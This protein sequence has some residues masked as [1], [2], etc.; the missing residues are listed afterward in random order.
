MPFI[1]FIHQEGGVLDVSSTER[2]PRRA[3]RKSQ[4]RRS[5]SEGTERAKEETQ[6]TERLNDA[7]RITSR[8]ERRLRQLPRHNGLGLFGLLFRDRF[9][10]SFPSQESLSD[11]TNA[12]PPDPIFILLALCTLSPL[13]TAFS[14]TEFT[15]DTL[16]I[17][18]LM[19]HRLVVVLDFHSLWAPSMCSKNIFG[20]DFYSSLS[21]TVFNSVPKYLHKYKRV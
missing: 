4:T 17:S 12:C 15:H 14:S 5:M 16:H 6:E 20:H 13:C 10:S 18:C 3:Y 21:R 8:M 7:A 1:S 19:R 11:H 2:R 9:T